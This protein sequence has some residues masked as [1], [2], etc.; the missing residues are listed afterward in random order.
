MQIQEMNQNIPALGL[1]EGDYIA[2]TPADFYCGAGTYIIGG[3]D[4][5][6]LVK[7]AETVSGEIHIAEINTASAKTVPASDFRKVV[8]G[9]VFAIVIL[10]NNMPTL[11]IDELRNVLTS[12]K[13]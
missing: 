8:K 7:C 2:T 4:G 6:V 13:K 12:P 11:A 10:E 9:K 5:N 1:K 3:P